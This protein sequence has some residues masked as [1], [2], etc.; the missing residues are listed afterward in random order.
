MTPNSHDFPIAIFAVMV[1][2]RRRTCL[3]YRK[4]RTMNGVRRVECSARSLL[5]R[6]VVHYALVA[7]NKEEAAKPN[8]N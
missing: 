7:D 8:R 4:L 1:L 3:M 5:Q 6:K 2:I